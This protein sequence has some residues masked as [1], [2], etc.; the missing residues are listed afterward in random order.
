MRRG[1]RLR[2]QSISEQAFERAAGSGRSR[3]RGTYVPGLC[4]WGHAVLGRRTAT[5]LTAPNATIGPRRNKKRRLPRLATISIKEMQARHGSMPLGMAI[6]PGAGNE[7][8]QEGLGVGNGSGRFCRPRARSSSVDGGAPPPYKRRF[9]KAVTKSWPIP[10]QPK[11]P[12][13]RA[14]AAPS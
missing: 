4:P 3:A 8:G 1:S 12:R 10:S 14:Y 7:P 11:R 2:T 13:A 9:T 6:R 5:P